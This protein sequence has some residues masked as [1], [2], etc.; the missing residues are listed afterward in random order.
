[1]EVMKGEGYSATGFAFYAPFMRRQW[2]R[3]ISQSPCV[4][5][6][7][8]ALLL[9]IR[10]DDQGV[11]QVTS[12]RQSDKFSSTERSGLHQIYMSHAK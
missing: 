10:C 4:F 2:I 5:C 1:M 6:K 8:I 11:E 12:R 9:Y 3:Q 7:Y